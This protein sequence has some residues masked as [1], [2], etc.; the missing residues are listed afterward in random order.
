[1]TYLDTLSVNPIRRLGMDAIRKAESGRPGTAR[2]MAP[3]A[4]PL[5]HRLLR[6][7]P[8]DLIWPD[9]DRSLHASALLSLLHLTELFDRQP[10]AYRDQVL[11]PTV[12]PRV[13]VKEA[14]T[15]G[16]GGTSATVGRSQV[17]TALAL[18]RPSNSCSTSAPSHL[19]V[20]PR[21]H[22]SWCHRARRHT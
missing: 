8:A 5:W 2:G 18:P 13:V 1:M 15:L 11:S 4:L 3:V 22:A 21:Q 20:S 7:D 10:R 14:S 17:C 19:S 12:T 16:W 9:P 6:F